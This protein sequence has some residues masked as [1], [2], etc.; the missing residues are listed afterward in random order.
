M[1]FPDGIIRKTIYSNDTCPDIIEPNEQIS[2]LECQKIS[3]NESCARTH[4]KNG[5]R[6]CKIVKR[7]N[8][9]LYIV[10]YLKLLLLLKRTTN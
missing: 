7:C 4:I 5:L 9:N 3:R 1:H 6:F 10:Y 2:C 8:M